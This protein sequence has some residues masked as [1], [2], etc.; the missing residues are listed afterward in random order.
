MQAT[1]QESKQ[2]D[3]Q[4]A[5]PPQPDRPSL[6][7]GWRKIPLRPEEGWATFIFL[8]FVIYSA[9]WSIQTVNWV[10]GLQ[11]LTWTTGAGLALGFIAAKQHK[12][13]R[14]LMHAIM[15]A[16][17][18][19][20]AFWATAVA[21]HGTIGSLWEHFIIWLRKA[22][23]PNTDTNDDVMFL[24]FL[25]VLSFIL[26]YVSVWLVARTRRPWLVTLATAIVLL[27]NLSYANGDLIYLTIFL[28]AG[29]LLLVRF[30]LSE[31]YRQWRRRSLRYTAD[32]GWDFM[33]AGMLFSVGILVFGWILPTA[34][35]NTSVANFWSSASNPWVSAQQLWE[36]LF[37]VRGGPGSSAYFSN[38]LR[39]TGNVDLPNTVILTYTTQSSGQ[40]LIAV[41][42]DF[43]DGQ[44]WHV[45][46][47]TTRNFD[48]KQSLGV[49]KTLYVPVDQ[50]IHL[51]NPP[52]G[53]PN[54]FIFAAADPSSFSVPVGTTRDV[55]GF[56]SY[57]A[58]G[59][60]VGGQNYTAT[61]FVS[62][63]DE[64]TL[65]Q[66]P[67]PADAQGGGDF[68]YP[69]DLLTRYTQVPLDLQSDQQIRQL[70]LD[71]TSGKTNMYD[72]VQAIENHLRSG[73]QY[74]QHN[75]DP[76]GNQDVVA[77]FLTQSKKGFCTYFASAM[78]MLARMLNIPARVASGYTNGTFDQDSGRWVV[79]GTDAHTWAQIYFPKYGWVNFEPST[80]FSSV[81]RPLPSVTPT[82]TETPGQDQTPVSK[83][84]PRVGID[85]NSGLDSG[86]AQAQ[87][88]DLRMRLLLGASGMLAVLILL[89]GATAIWWRRL[90]RGMSPVAQTFGRVT[91]LAGWA[92]LKPKPTQTPFE[93]MD[94]LQQHLPVQSESLQRLSELY[95]QDR[96]GAADA[97]SGVLA[98][99]R[100]LWRRLR[101]SLV[102]AVMRRP[103]LNPLVWARLLQ[104]RRHRRVK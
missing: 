99:L 31:A 85:P 76:P 52:S 39:L 79:R 84:T 78:V 46:G 47:T 5:L 4:E 75:P 42:Q 16:A 71:W 83:P 98:E 49:D 86:S 68:F 95:V 17:G 25:A 65:R 32:L 48:A 43:F 59:P 66:V 70:A 9:V 103:S 26:A 22:V 96:W 53:N 50:N 82:G 81:I 73:Y 63:A 18:F 102:R 97:E 13:S 37:Q 74:S 57:F 100:Q 3:K 27:I 34:G 40:Y 60:L 88:A 54:Q 19:L 51:V 35:Q 67:L 101:G 14:L 20:L 89:F 24:L 87:A 77:W 6:F 29:L 55:S 44:V 92:G 21:Y 41:T 7:P 91:L 23:T 38:Q 93:Y 11:I 61:S 8:G 58:R 30:N 10:N 90:F 12:L 64:N 56:T 15:M 104:E 2:E 33:V 1:M 36:R 28:L 62:L 69:P 94:G 80:G 72:M 45:T